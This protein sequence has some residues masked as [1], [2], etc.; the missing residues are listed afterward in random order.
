MFLEVPPPFRASVLS[1]YLIVF[2]ADPICGSL[3]VPRY[4]AH[5]DVDPSRLTIVK[6]RF[7]EHRIPQAMREMEE[8]FEGIGHR[9][10]RMKKRG[11]Q[12]P[13]V[14]AG[15]WNLSR[16]FDDHLSIRGPGGRVVEFRTS[17]ET[18]VLRVGRQSDRSP[19]HERQVLMSVTV[20][21]SKGDPAVFCEY[22][23]GFGPQTFLGLLHFL[24][25]KLEVE[26]LEYVSREAIWKSVRARL[27]QDGY[28]FE[29]KR[30]YIADH[31]GISWRATSPA[32]EALVGRF[33]TADEYPSLQLIYPNGFS[34]LPP[35]FLP[36][37][38]GIRTQIR[39]SE[40]LPENFGAAQRNASV[41]SL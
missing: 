27:A 12:L 8:A 22:E 3:T 19:P 7:E 28:A 36:L 10:D 18:S 31:H 24:G 14:F 30:P 35:S 20:E 39:N 21:R 6:E 26:R 38:D 2:E 13:R 41:H 25:V 1:S 16:Y 33:W 15:A 32:G 5:D 37:W 23:F 17:Y 40:R 34:P 29:Q 11:D 9:L 4:Y